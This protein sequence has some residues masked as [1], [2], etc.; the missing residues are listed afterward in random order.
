MHSDQ[1]AA[2]PATLLDRYLIS[3][4]DE[5]LDGAWASRLFTEDAV[6]EFPMSRHTGIEGLA[7][8]H[9]DSL[10]AF[11]ATQ[12]LAGPT[13]VD[14][15]ADDRVRLR[16]NLVSTHVHLGATPDTELFVA[17]TFATGEARRDP[18]GTWRLSSLSL[19]VV[20]RTGSPSG[21]Q[22]TPS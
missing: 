10:A 14:R 18:G 1:Q 19:R 8:Y 13:V 7:E 17:G 11:S 9:R 4:D 20:W 3:L 21:P 12:H 15:L 16:A 5:K 6:V 2:S 22:D